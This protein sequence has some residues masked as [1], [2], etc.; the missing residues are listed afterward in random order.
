[1]GACHG[2]SK[3]PP[4]QF[5]AIEDQMKQACVTELE[6]VNAECHTKMQNIFHNAEGTLRL[7]EVLQ[8]SMILLKRYEENQ[9]MGVEEDAEDKLRKTLLEFVN[10]LGDSKNRH[11]CDAVKM[12]NETAD[13]ATK[14]WL[15][16][17]LNFAS[18]DGAQS[19][20]LRHS[21]SA[22]KIKSQQS[23]HHQASPSP[24]NSAKTSTSGTQGV[25]SNISNPATP[26]NIQKS[27]TQREATRRSSLLAIPDSVPSVGDNFNSWDFDV[28]LLEPSDMKRLVIQAMD[29][30]GLIE[31]FSLSRPKLASFVDHTCRGYHASNA[32]HNFHHAVDVF[33]A[34]VMFL[35]STQ[36]Q[37]RANLRP[38]H[39]LGLLLAALSH[40]IG[41]T[42]TNNPFHVQT[43]SELS[44]IYNDVSVLENHHAATAFKILQTEDCAILSDFS[45]ATWTELRKI[46]IA[47]ILATDMSHHFGMVGKLDGLLQR[48]ERQHTFSD[49]HTWYAKSSNKV[50]GNAAALTVSDADIQQLISAV[51]HACDI[52][53][54][55]KKWGIS[56]KWSERI[57]TE[58]I[59]QGKLEKAANLTVSPFM[60]V[61]PE[62]QPQMS[63]NFIDF[64]VAP[65]NLKMC[66]AFPALRA[67]GVNVVNNRHKWNQQLLKLK[68]EKA[69]ELTQRANKFKTNFTELL[70]AA[71][72]TASNGNGN[73]PITG[74][75][76]PL[77]LNRNL[78]RGNSLSSPITA[79][80]RG[81][82]AGS[83][84]GDLTSRRSTLMLNPNSR[85]TSNEY[86]RSRKQSDPPPMMMRK[87]SPKN[88]NVGKSDKGKRY[89]MFT[90]PSRTVRP[91]GGAL[92]RTTS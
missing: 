19:D 5:D 71:P 53:N 45:V 58:Y 16:A 24:R 6:Q 61:K 75:R 25:T 44:I 52:S 86:T 68:P 63:L 54:P 69:D 81:S 92:A 39:V 9:E 85:K 82:A 21:G 27:P 50:A 42:G 29:G 33:H 28:L 80:A 11:H 60:D 26:S 12:A 17:E 90:P 37:E 74:E 47:C 31:H 15:E 10:H 18:I 79:P 84:S 89:S 56:K 70:P 40:D 1:M 35:R 51:L 55:T 88:F 8:S 64:I 72:A 38:I 36:L 73:V 76:S 66:T 91:L 46:M 2:S 67:L 22:E 77:L 14:A 65:L 34:S 43:K 41:H 62:N 23:P 3:A 49:L 30:L 32:Y 20:A 7:D 59:E 13:P 57:T 48:I 83:A 87:T 78:G 4:D